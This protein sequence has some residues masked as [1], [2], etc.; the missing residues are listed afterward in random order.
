MDYLDQQ[1]R[2]AVFEYTIGKINEKTRGEQK[3]FR[4]IPCWQQFA[5]QF[6]EYLTRY[7]FFVLEGKSRTGKSSWVFWCCNDPSKVF[8]V[9][10]ANCMEPDLRKFNWMQHKVILLD[11]A[12]PQ[13]VINQK[14][15]M[16]CPPC[17]VK[18]G[19]SS[20][21][22]HAYD[23]FVSGIMMIICSNTWEDDVNAMY[24]KGDRDWIRE[25]Q[26]YYNTGEEPLFYTEA[27]LNFWWS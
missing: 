9:N 27:E 8:Y 21:N 6:T 23:V 15:L 25:N 18:L 12:S 1:L 7:M 17:L 2:N 26:I 22:C 11:E 16:Q 13:M 24:K 20:T 10:C 5:D 14:L 19:Q 4:E 3:P